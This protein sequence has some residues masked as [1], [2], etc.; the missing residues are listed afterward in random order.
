MLE[1]LTIVFF[2]GMVAAA[3]GMWKADRDVHLIQNAL[4]NCKLALE[5]AHDENTDMFHQL[6]EN[7]RTY[8]ERAVKAAARYHAGTMKYEEVVSASNA[9]W[10]EAAKQN[11]NLAEQLAT[12]RLSHPE[13][14]SEVEEH[15]EEVSPSLPYSAELEDYLA[16]L[17]SVG[18]REQAIEYIDDHRKYGLDDEQIIEKLEEE[19]T[20]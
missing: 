12:I 14:Y 5:Q 11:A 15:I 7:I 1:I 17:N 8:E 3:M 20:A 10:I 13:A 9:R 16:G 18:A 6:S 4:E 19:W 2:I